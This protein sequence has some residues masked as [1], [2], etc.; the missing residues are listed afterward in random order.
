MVTTATSQR[1]DTLSAWMNV[2]RPKRRFE[3]LK[4]SKSW[5]NQK[6]EPEKFWKQENESEINDNYGWKKILRKF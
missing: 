5:V 4:K 3:K 6:D 2:P 1:T